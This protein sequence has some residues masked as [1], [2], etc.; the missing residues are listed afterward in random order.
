ML[1]IL[2]CTK[3]QTG[4]RN[5]ISTVL[6]RMLFPVRFW[7]FLYFYC[8]SNNSIC[9]TDFKMKKE[10]NVLR[11]LNLWCNSM[12]MDLAYI[13][14]MHHLSLLVKEKNSI[15]SVRFM[16]S[17]VGDPIPSTVSKNSIRTIKNSVL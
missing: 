5:A 2:N 11:S 9:I 16:I 15:V 7:A 6:E 12:K 14:E 17:L 1:V 4:L 13:S 3:V 10:T 8:I